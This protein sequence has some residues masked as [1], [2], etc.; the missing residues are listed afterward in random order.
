MKS[1]QGNPK[2]VRFVMCMEYMNIKK[3]MKGQHGFQ[4]HCLPFVKE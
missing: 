3:K 1:K 2:H 4:S